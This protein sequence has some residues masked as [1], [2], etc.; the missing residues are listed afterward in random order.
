MK[1][2]KEILI[3]EKVKLARYTKESIGASKI[4]KIYLK[5][6]DFINGRVVRKTQIIKS[7]NPNYGD[8][9]IIVDRKTGEI[10]RTRTTIQLSNVKNINKSAV[11]LAQ[12]TQLNMR[13]KHERK[14]RL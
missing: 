14:V 11:K 10:L 13:R 5:T 7:N 6:D 8:K 4:R 9:K 3:T 2:G 1:N 12:N